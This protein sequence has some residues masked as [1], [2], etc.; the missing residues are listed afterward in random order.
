MLLFWQ[1]STIPT[2]VLWT[3][4]MLSGISSV[5]ECFASISTSVA[6]LA[7]N[8]LS[9]RALSA[10]TPTWTNVPLSIVCNHSTGMVALA[11]SKMLEHWAASVPCASTPT[12][13]QYRGQGLGFSADDRRPSKRPT[14]TSVGMLPGTAPAASQLPLLTLWY[15][16]CAPEDQSHHTARASLFHTY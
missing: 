13:R 11:H 4:Q 6:F 16:R 2:G 3:A 8:A 5:T 12:L 10:A 1:E 14:C 7:S 15:G 9:C